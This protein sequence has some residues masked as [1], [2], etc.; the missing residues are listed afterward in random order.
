MRVF[1]RL[2]ALMLPVCA[3]AE[4]APVILQTHLNPPYQVMETSGL[5]GQIP[6][7]LAC[8]FKKMNR[9]YAI[10]VAPRKRNRELVRTQR[11]DG[12]FLSIPD[13]ELDKTSIASQPL[14]LERWNL[15]RLKNSSQPFERSS[16]G[17]VLG[18]NE[19][20]WL[21][22][23]GI[24]L[25]ATIPNVL[26]LAKLLKSGRVSAVLA[27]D[28]VFFDALETVNYPKEKIE[29]IFIRYVPLVAYF[30]K[31]FIIENP[32][33]MQQFNLA[34]WGCVDKKQ[35]L[36][37]TEN[38]ELLQQVRRLLQ[39][40]E[41]PLRSFI[42]SK[43]D[44]YP[45]AQAGLEEDRKWHLVREKGRD[46][47]L[48]RQIMA[49]AGSVFLREIAQENLGV[50]EAFLTDEDGFNVAMSVV[51][52]DYWQGDEL[53]FKSLI[54]GK[55]SY[56]SPI[57]FDHSTRSFQVQVSVALMDPFSNKF[58]GMLTLGFDVDKIFGEGLARFFG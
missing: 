43:Q 45:V 1:V 51:T 12:F 6:K 13:Q 11:I 14:A 38:N 47:P 44:A 56:V 54:T 22:R 15:F 49:N 48:I 28:G 3:Q 39:K 58:L 21:A 7:V 9:P 8:I 20:I 2:F 55:A 36:H 24:N 26:S 30:S 4:P 29:A 31:D 27:D 40:Y 17:S 53:A 32:G 37:D 41:V 35:A 5:G 10:T 33:F 19:E 16:I 57:R 46:T 52:S 50:S 34:I 18:A 42:K 25:K 23:H